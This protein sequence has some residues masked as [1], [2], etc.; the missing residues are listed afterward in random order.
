MLSC[1]RCGKRVGP[2]VCGGD[3][4]GP[5]CLACVDALGIRLRWGRRRRRTFS[6]TLKRWLREVKT[7]DWYDERDAW[8]CNCGEFVTDGCHCSTCGAEPPW[9]CPCS[10]C[11]GE[12]YADDDTDDGCYFDPYDDCEPDPFEGALGEC[13]RGQDYEGCMNAGTEYCDFECPFNR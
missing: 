6:V 10:W 1:S 2:L 11:Q 3:A 5:L 12:R 9:G 7:G 13:G 4:P 8:L